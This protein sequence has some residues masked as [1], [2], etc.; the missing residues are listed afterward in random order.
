MGALPLFV[1]PFCSFSVPV[2][3]GQTH[4]VSS[5]SATLSA[6]L[7]DVDRA[8]AIYIFV[9]AK[10]TLQKKSSIWQG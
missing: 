4:N 6:N 8:L 1:K 7:R 3:Q 9:W 2:S 10:L 5:G